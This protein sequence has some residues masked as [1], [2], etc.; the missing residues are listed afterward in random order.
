MKDYF[1]CLTVPTSENFHKRSITITLK[2]VV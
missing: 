1:D 2:Q